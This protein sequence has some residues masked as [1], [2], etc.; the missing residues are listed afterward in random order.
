MPRKIKSK[1]IFSCLFI[2]SAGNW[3]KSRVLDITW[4]KNESTQ[5]KVYQINFLVD[6][7]FPQKKI[8]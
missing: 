3:E 5:S 4:V 7:G 6:P 2:S 1:S 8:M